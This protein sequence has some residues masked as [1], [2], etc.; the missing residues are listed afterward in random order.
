MRV[1]GVPPEIDEK[2]FKVKFLDLDGRPGL[3][4]RSDREAMP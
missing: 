1:I 3:R 2:R 4:S